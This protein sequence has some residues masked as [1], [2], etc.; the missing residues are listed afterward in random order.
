MESVVNQSTVGT[1]LT[2]FGVIAYA[3]EPTSIFTL[4]EYDSR[5]EV[6]TAIGNVKPTGGNTYTG[7]ALTYSLP[8]FN[9]EHGGRR[10]SKVPQI[11]MVITDGDATNPHNLKKPSDMLRDHGVTVFSIGVKDANVAQ[12]NIIAGG[13][14]SKVFYVDKFKDLEPLYKNIS[15]VLCNYVKPGKS[16]LFKLSEALELF[17]L[18]H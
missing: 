12:L 13:D 17:R 15:G 11:L 14:K 5:R 6:V 1:N 2:R 10:K 9:A 8:Y 4:K 7:K 16:P 18:S 3:T